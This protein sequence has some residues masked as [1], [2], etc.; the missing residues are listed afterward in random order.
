LPIEPAF[1]IHIQNVL[2]EFAFSIHIENLCQ[3]RHIGLRDW[4][5]QVRAL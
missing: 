4:A 1:R 3:S 2:T 5:H